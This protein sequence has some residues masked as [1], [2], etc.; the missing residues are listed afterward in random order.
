MPILQLGDIVREDY[1]VE[2]MLGEGAFAE[3]YRV[4]HRLWE[5]RDH[6][7]AMKVLKT[8]F[9]S[10][11]ELKTQLKE[12]WLLRKLEHP[13]I[14][15]VHDLGLINR[16][17][18]QFGWFTM[19]YLPGG[20]LHNYWRRYGKQLMPVAETVEIV[21]QAC[22]GL[23]VAHQKTPPVI[24]RDIKP[25][26]ILIGFDGDALIAKVGD[27]GLARQVNPLTMLASARGTLAFKPP[28]ALEDQ[29]STASD[30]WGIGASLYLLLTD[31]LPHPEL[32]DRGIADARRFLQPLRPPSFYN[33]TVDAVLDAVVLGC[34]AA[35][36]QDRYGSIGDLAA[37]LAKWTPGNLEAAR[38][39]S[40]SSDALSG[41]AWKNRP[42]A[43]SQA[44]T[45][46]DSTPEDMVREAL[47]LA[48]TVG[49]L[50]RATE[51]LEAALVRKPE[52]RV[53]Y[54]DRLRNW[55]R[56]VAM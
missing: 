16:G 49:R 19:E 27:F 23:A 41:S 7:M 50:A 48:R 10:L 55:R 17:G 15:R 54:G 2:R 4:E 43:A 25:Q 38:A 8:P 6:R 31:M 26:N 39:P 30:V 45:S 44:A 3:V 13:N 21:A 40:M 9:D 18:K 51:I 20:N 52:L 24:H 28:E 11:D 34:L 42:A 32:D 29:D 47:R 1:R 5:G 37:D 14:V 33:I 53:R 36:P 56:G 46:N 35:E 12:A 22:R